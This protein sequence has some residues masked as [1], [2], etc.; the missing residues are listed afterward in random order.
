[1][2]LFA[3]SCVPSVWAT[4]ILAESFQ[5]GPSSPPVGRAGAATAAS[6]RLWGLAASARRRRQLPG[7][8]QATGPWP[9]PAAPAPRRRRCQADHPANHPLHALP[10]RGAA[11]IILSDYPLCRAEQVQ[12]KLWDRAMSII[13]TRCGFTMGP[14]AVRGAAAQLT[15]GQCR[16]CALDMHGCSGVASVA[17]SH[18]PVHGLLRR[19]MMLVPAMLHS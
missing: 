6:W 19:L 4:S 7:C 11:E 10:G 12:A 2:V 14:R 13:D 16:G 17:A 1:M 15:A 18:A 8:L 5:L 3:Y 9:P